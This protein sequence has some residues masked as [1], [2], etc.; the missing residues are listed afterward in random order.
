[1][2]VRFA[3]NKRGWQ[4]HEQYVQELLG[5][6]S[7]ICSGN[8]FND[9]GDGVDR[10]HPSQKLFPL[11][12]DAKYTE[13]QSFSIKYAVLNEW[14]D[15]AAEMGKRFVMPIRFFPKWTVEPIDYVLLSL[16]DFAEL[17]DAAR[18]GQ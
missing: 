6:S 16:D 7:T 12:V 18:H 11:I 14:W 4:A 2:I 3:K 9:P 17:L 5:L 8:Q 1:M 15:K 13:K 10:D